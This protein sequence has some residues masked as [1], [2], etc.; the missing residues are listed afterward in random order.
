MKHVTWAA[1]LLAAL[2]LFSSG[3]ADFP[4]DYLL[5]AYEMEDTYR[6]FC[7]TTTLSD[8]TDEAGPVLCYIS[9]SGV[10]ACQSLDN[11]PRGLLAAVVLQLPVAVSHL[12]CSESTLCGLTADG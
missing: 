4:D 11:D 10:P 5:A 9:G 7:V 12:A 6:L 1:S 3:R 8:G 2:L